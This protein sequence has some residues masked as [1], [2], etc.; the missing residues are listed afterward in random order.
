MNKSTLLLFLSANQ[1]HAQHLLAG[2]VVTQRSFANQPEGHAEFAAFTRS[3]ACPAYLLTDLIEED[4][5]QESVPHLLGGSR[6]AL[7]QRKLDQYY[8]NTPF[9]QTSLLQRQKAGRRD[10]D[11]LFSAL[12]NPSLITPWLNALLAQQIPL[13][14]IFSVPQISAPLIKDHPSEHLLLVSQAR[15]SGLRQ[16]YFSNHRLQISRLTPITNTSFAEAVTNELARTYQY[17]KSLSLLPVGQVLDV[18]ILCHG[19]DRIKLQQA[20]PNSGEIHYDFIDLATLGEKLKMADTFV[21]SD[22]TP[23][24]LHQ[25]LTHTPKTSYANDDHVHH[26][27]LWKLRRALMLASIPMLLPSLLW[28]GVNFWQSY[29]DEQLLSSTRE[30]A[31]QIE[32]AAT[33]IIQGFP[34]T[35]HAPASG[36][37]D[38]VSAMH[39]LEHYQERPEDVLKPLGEILNRYPQIEL[40]DLAWRFSGEEPVMPDTLSSVPAQVISLAGHLSGFGNNYRAALDYLE[41][42]QQAFAQRGYHV[43]VLSKPLDISPSGSI[44]DRRETQSET[45]DFSLKLAWRPPA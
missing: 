30:Q 4:F 34:N 28:S 38:A 27:Q 39:D 18:R 1:L 12:T 42:F 23:I 9:R 6:R 7:L 16:T 45:L 36:M 31:Q 14:G 19:D 43:T 29:Q 32:S 3:I 25:L 5:R 17:L 13:V 8:R 40:G 11:M 21:D 2:R 20:L 37:K 15:A 22:A 33:Q 41:Q 44:D 26:H 10:D 35:I 24:F